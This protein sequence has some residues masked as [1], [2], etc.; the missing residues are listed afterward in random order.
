MIVLKQPVSPKNISTPMGFK[1][2]TQGDSV[3]F[4]KHLKGASWCEKEKGQD[5][6][7]GIE[8]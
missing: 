4:T 2:P 8:G 5:E 3:H 1:S 7:R 6:R